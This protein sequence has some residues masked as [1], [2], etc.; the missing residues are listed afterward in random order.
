MN[1]LKKF[2]SLSSY[3]KSKRR[4]TIGKKQ[5]RNRHT[6]RYKMRGGWGGNGPSSTPIIENP[7]I[8]YLKY[9]GVGGWGPAIT[10]P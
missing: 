3:K 9:K 4:R 5:K 2:L 6:R 1:R 8:T 10:L 7:D